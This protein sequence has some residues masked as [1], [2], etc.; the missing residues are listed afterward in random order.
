MGSE[1]IKCTFQALG[2][3]CEIVL[4]T[5]HEDLAEECFLLVK[6]EVERIEQKILAISRRQRRFND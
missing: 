3:R 4:D 5:A 1:V 2:S 6:S